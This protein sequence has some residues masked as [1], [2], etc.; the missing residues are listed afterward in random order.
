MLEIAGADGM[1]LNTLETF[2]VLFW[3]EPKIFYVGILKCLFWRADALVE[4]LPSHSFLGNA[5][6]GSISSDSDNAAIELPGAVIA[7]V[8][9]L[10]DKHE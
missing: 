3:H 6:R 8:A 9:E 10:S 5:V 7:W 4:T 1:L 2:R